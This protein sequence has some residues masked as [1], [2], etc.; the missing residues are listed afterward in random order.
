MKLTGARIAWLL[1]L[2][3]AAALAMGVLMLRFALDTNPGAI[4]PAAPPLTKTSWRNGEK[5]VHQGTEERERVGT[6]NLIDAQKV[7]SQ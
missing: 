1:F 5:L 2:P 7:A 6:G 4:A 3:P